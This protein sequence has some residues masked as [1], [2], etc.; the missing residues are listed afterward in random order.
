MRE[1]CT[2]ILIDASPER[3]WTVLVNLERFSDWNPFIPYA[4]GVIEKDARLEVRI[5]P[6]GSR[7]MA[8]QPTVTRLVPERELHWLGHLW[9]P[10]LFDGEH[11][12]ELHP[13]G[14]AGTRFVQRER[15]SGL[16]VPLIWNQVKGPTRSGFVTMNEALKARAE[17]VS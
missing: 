11:I 8:F 3:V 4:Q 15:F 7:A 16:L 14:E 2:D 12:F 17:R 1:V 13:E 6:P 9:I 5:T 10:K